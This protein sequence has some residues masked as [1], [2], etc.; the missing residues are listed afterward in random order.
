MRLLLTRLLEKEGDAGRLAL[1]ANGQHPG[2]LHRPGPHLGAAADR[3]LAGFGP[4]DG[5][6]SL[7]GFSHGIVTLVREE[8]T[9]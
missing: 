3:V 7:V 2:F 8:M 9:P 1:V 4:L 5:E 6:R